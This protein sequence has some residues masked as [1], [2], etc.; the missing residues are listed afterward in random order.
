MMNFIL[1]FKAFLI[2][3]ALCFLRIKSLNFHICLTKIHQRQKASGFVSLFC[4]NFYHLNRKIQH[5]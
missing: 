5:F 2:S 3:K 1:K 4:V